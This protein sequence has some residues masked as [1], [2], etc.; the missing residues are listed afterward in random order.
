MV[1]EARWSLRECLHQRGP[2]M[3]HGQHRQ[4]RG[5]MRHR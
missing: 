2:R 4:H 3:G 5:R 1:P